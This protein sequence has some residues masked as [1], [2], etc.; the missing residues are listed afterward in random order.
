MSDRPLD[1]NDGADGDTVLVLDIPEHVVAEYEWSGPPTRQLNGGRPIAV[2]DKWC[3]R[4][5]DLSPSH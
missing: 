5:A 2:S 3:M 1:P 4:G